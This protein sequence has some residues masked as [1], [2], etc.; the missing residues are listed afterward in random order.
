LVTQ[1]YNLLRTLALWW[2]RR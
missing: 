1:A 2:T